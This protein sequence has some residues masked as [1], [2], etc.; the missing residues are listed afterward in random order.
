MTPEWKDAF[1]FAAAEA[2]DNGLE[3]AIA[4]SPGWSETG[5]PWVK[6]KEA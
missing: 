6:A 4:A 5:G 1:R 3:M 2:G